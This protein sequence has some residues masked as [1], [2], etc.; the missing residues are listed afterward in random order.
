MRSIIGV[1]YH[2]IRL[3]AQNALQKRFRRSDGRSFLITRSLPSFTIMSKRWRMAH[4]SL[5]DIPHC[6]SL[7]STHCIPPVKTAGIKRSVY[8]ALSRQMTGHKQQAAKTK[9]LLI[10]VTSIVMFVLSMSDRFAIESSW[11]PA[12]FVLIMRRSVPTLPLLLRTTHLRVVS[13]VLLV[14]TGA[15]SRTAP[16]ALRTLFPSATYPT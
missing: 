1:L 13:C 9:I 7:R 10:N 5:G 4:R 11:A 16:S 3:K 14:D 8:V 6:I 12:L 2:Y 15:R